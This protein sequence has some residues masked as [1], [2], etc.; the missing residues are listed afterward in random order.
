MEMGVGFE[1]FAGA[2]IIGNLQNSIHH[3]TGIWMAVRRQA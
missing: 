2:G 1:S 3:L